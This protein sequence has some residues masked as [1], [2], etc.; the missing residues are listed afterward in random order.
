MDTQLLKVRAVS[1]GWGLF[2]LIIIA[3]SGVLLSPDFSALVKANF[4]DSAFVGFALLLVPEVVK[5]LRNLA[6]VKKLGGGDKK[7]FLI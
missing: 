2:S 7:I 4:G 1:F 5:H 6:E 3:I